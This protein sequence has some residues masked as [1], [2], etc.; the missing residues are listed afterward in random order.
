MLQT[1]A[2]QVANSATN[3]LIGA[4]LPDSASTLGSLFRL[5]GSLCVVL[6]ILFV[7]VWLLR[8]WQR[9]ASK[10]GARPAL[11]VVESRSLGQRQSLYIVECGDQRFLIGGSPSGLNLLSTL[12]AVPEPAS[13]PVPSP[14]P[15]PVPAPASFANALMQAL[16]RPT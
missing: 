5:L 4:G 9:L 10:N 11:R 12:S 15:R 16:G 7:G 1:N 3:A 14:N 2:M 8:H 6:G 13:V